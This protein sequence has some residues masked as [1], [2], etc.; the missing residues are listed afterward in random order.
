M[1]R[2]LI[3]IVVVIIVFQTP[4]ARGRLPRKTRPISNSPTQKKMIRDS[5]LPRSAPRAGA[6]GTEEREVIAD[7][8]KHKKHQH[9]C[10]FARDASVPTAVEAGGG[11]TVTPL[12]FQTGVVVVVV[13]VPVVVAAVAADV[14]GFC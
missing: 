12:I 3:G 2:S 4:L 13:V 8:P 1:F 9:T 14:S 10:P 11:G 5:P 7:H 6:A